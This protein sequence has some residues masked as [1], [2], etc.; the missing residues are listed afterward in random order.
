MNK[1]EI[2]IQG[3]I[4]AQEYIYVLL[5]NKISPYEYN[6]DYIHVKNENMNYNYYFYLPED[7]VYYENVYIINN[8]NEEWYNFLNEL[9]FESKTFGNITVF[10]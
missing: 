7:E 10:Y 3:D 5:D 1:E 9:N 2:F 8:S 4:N 6:T